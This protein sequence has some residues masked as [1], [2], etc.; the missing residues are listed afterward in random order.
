MGPVSCSLARMGNHS[1]GL[2][3]APSQGMGPSL[4]APSLL[5]GKE[6][7]WAGE[8][9]SDSADGLP[10]YPQGPRAGTDPGIQL[11]LSYLGAASCLASL[12][13]QCWAENKAWLHG[14]WPCP[15]AGRST[16]DNLN[17]GEKFPPS[18][19]ALPKA[20][21]GSVF[22]Q[23]GV[24]WDGCSLASGDRDRIQPLS[25]TSVQDLRVQWV[26]GWGLGLQQLSGS[27]LGFHDQP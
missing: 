7:P 8:V 11:L 5:Q 19:C 21:P 4:G 18:P 12:R 24:Q 26:Q 1:Q 20:R 6:L 2:L 14:E 25:C 3:V 17:W 16:Q 10:L 22:S 13:D 23:V 27:I 9:L 15:K